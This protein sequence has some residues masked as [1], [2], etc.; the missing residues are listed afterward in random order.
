MIE[1]PPLKVK[2]VVLLLEVIGHTLEMI[3]SN[4]VSYR[5]QANNQT[6]ITEMSL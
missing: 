6:F 2:Q 4:E 1:M 5:Y 3:P